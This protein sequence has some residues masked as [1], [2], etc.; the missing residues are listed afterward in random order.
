MALDSGTVA[1][2]I[3]GS[4]ALVTV[5]GATYSSVRSGKDKT[6]RAADRDVAE[7]TADKLKA[8]R[9]QIT[10][11]TRAQVLQELR[12]DLDRARKNL[13]DADAKLTAAHKEVEVLRQALSEKN[14]QID[15]QNRM[16]GNLTRRAEVLESWIHDNQDKFN[17]IGIPCLPEDHGHDRDHSVESEVEEG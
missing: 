1:A 3:S 6:D 12:T 2:L 9:D 17:N 5:L 8:E 16:I 10:E 14:E 7:A 13:N 4:G 11:Q 15:R